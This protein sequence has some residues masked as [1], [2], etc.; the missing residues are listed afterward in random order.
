MLAR[1]M[2][3]ASIGV[4]SPYGRFVATCPSIAAEIAKPMSFTAPTSV[5]STDSGVR[6]PWATPA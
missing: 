1:L 2:T 6:R 4:G 5:T 3:S